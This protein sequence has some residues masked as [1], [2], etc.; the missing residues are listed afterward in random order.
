[1]QEKN[2]LEVHKWP[3]L[4]QFQKMNIYVYVKIVDWNEAM[5]SGNY[6]GAEEWIAEPVAAMGVYLRVFIICMKLWK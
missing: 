3:V 5:V 4:E 1:M 6:L 2:E